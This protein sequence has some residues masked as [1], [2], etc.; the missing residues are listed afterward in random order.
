M[1]Y[2]LQLFNSRLMQ[3]EEYVSYVLNF[4]LVPKA[5]DCGFVTVWHELQKDDAIRY[6]SILK[7]KEISYLKL[8]DNTGELVYSGTPLNIHE[9][10]H[11]LKHLT[12]NDSKSIGGID[13]TT[14]RRI[15]INL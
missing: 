10:Q 2:R 3:K 8:F 6:E 5:I 14:F 9:L 1:I 4:N 13:E 7:E 15:Q 11:K 12:R